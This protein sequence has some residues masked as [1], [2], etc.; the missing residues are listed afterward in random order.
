[1][2][3]AVA[4]RQRS[5]TAED[6]E[7][8]LH[9]LAI[10]N[11]NHRLAHRL[12]AEQGTDIPGDTLYDWKA[13][14]HT[15]RYEQ[16]RAEVLPQLKDRMAAE[17]ETLA[18]AYAHIERKALHALDGKLD[19]LTGKELAGVAKDAATGRGISTDKANVLRD[20][21]DRIVKNPNADEVMR[22]LAIVVPGLIVESTAAE[23]QDDEP[24]PALPAPHTEPSQETR[25]RVTEDGPSGLGS[26][27]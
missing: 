15:E 26:R 25:V 21:P 18:I 11:G 3:S 7:A 13:K 16:I 14:R 12:L 17:A 4:D 8:G 10:A 27:S 22:K 2:S 24:T 1:M 19:G 6:I 5:Y 9:A 23:I 20:R